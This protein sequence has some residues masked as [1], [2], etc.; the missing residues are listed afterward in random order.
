MA[1]PSH[2]DG[3]AQNNLYLARDREVIKRHYPD[4]TRDKA[5]S[6]GD[7]REYEAYVMALGSRAMQ[8]AP[9]RR[10][11]FETGLTHRDR[12]ASFKK[13]PSSRAKALHLELASAYRVLDASELQ[14]KSFGMESTRTE[15]AMKIMASKIGESLVAGKVPRLSEQGARNCERTRNELAGV[16]A[17]A[18]KTNP[19]PDAATASPKT[20]S[21]DVER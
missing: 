5:A 2:K 6:T 14:A 3:Q 10:E 17:A 1:W 13:L 21:Q 4:L 18:I 20:P 19:Q 15:A 11:I 16:E 8:A 9:Q 12:A 7:W